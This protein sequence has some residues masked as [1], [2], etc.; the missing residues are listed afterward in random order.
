MGDVSNPQRRGIENRRKELAKWHRSP[1]WIAFRDLHARQ[2][3]AICVHCGKKHGEVRKRL[4]GEDKV[5]KS[6]NR[7]G[8]P[9]LVNLTVNHISRRKYISLKEYLTWDDDCEV[10]CDLCNMM[11]E[12]GKKPCP[13]CKAR[14]IMWYETE[15]DHC[16]YERFPEL[17]KEKLDN[18]AERERRNREFKKKMATKRRIAK[19]KHPCSYHGINQKCRGGF[20][21][22]EHSPSKAEKN[23][24]G[25]K[26]KVKK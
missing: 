14:Y 8:Q 21:A 11:F 12:K 9:V 6:G 1:E 7:K 24:R 26:Q 23:C 25:F 17:L 18:I 20:F 16:Y 15:C 19:V 4:D 5:Y 22:C 13:T 10:C 2:I 3:R